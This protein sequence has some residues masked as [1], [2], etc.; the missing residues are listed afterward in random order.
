[1]ELSDPEPCALGPFADQAARSG[2]AQQH[3]R[4]TGQQLTDDSDVSSS[5]SASGQ[6]GTPMVQSNLGLQRYFRGE[7]QAR[8]GPGW[9]PAPFTKWGHP[10]TPKEAEQ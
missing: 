10:E 1:M 6:P 8:G 7:P 9:K 4:P 3:Q 5:R 2:A